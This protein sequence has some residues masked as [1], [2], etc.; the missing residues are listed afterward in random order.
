MQQQ[1][2]PSGRV[3]LKAGRPLDEWRRRLRAS[4]ATRSR[5]DRARF[6]RGLRSHPPDGSLSAAEIDQLIASLEFEFSQDVADQIHL[7]AYES[8]LPEIVRCQL[9]VP[10]LHELRAHMTGRL[11]ISTTTWTT[12]APTSLCTVMRSLP[13]SYLRQCAPDCAR[14]A[15]DIMWQRQQ[16]RTRARA[17]A[18]RCRSLV[19]NFALLL[20][21]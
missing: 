21:Y 17:G 14:Y 8:S 5:A 3:P 16:G 12:G 13:L 9:R 20:A 19:R 6:L 15:S 4:C 1:Q 7:A 10:A 18:S 2:S 11:A